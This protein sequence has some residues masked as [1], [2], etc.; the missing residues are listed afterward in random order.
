MVFVVPCFP[1]HLFASFKMAKALQAR[2]HHVTYL[3][4]APSESYVKNQGIPFVRIFKRLQEP[5]LDPIRMS[6]WKRYQIRK[7]IVRKVVET[8]D[9]FFEEEMP[10]IIRK[11]NPDLFVVD[12]G[13]P[14]MG[15][16]SYRFNIPTVLLSGWLPNTRDNNIPL[17]SSSIIPKKTWLSDLKSRWSWNIFLWRRSLQAKIG[18]KL[19]GIDLDFEEITR[20]FAVKAGYPLTRVDLDT[21]LPTPMLS[22]I[23][24]LVMCPE[25]F[26][27][28]RIPKAMIHYIEPAND[29]ERNFPKDVKIDWNQFDPHKPLLFVSFGN[30]SH[31]YPKSK[32]F[33]QK[34]I[35]VV[36]K[37]NEW[38][39]ILAVGEKYQVQEFQNQSSQ[40]L[41]VNCVSPFD[42]LPRA[43]LMVS[44]GGLNMIKEA[45]AHAVPMLLFPLSKHRDQFGNAA[46]VV[47]HQIGLRGNVDTITTRELQK[48]I[49]QVLYD[50]HIHQNI[51]VMKKVFW[52]KE[53]EERG[54]RFLETYMTVHK[55]REQE[56]G[57]AFDRS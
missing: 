45:I 38:Q 41:V 46:R 44:H 53:K 8:Y 33:F 15:L 31:L 13:W 26:D 55:R 10:E 12:H 7:E 1:G 4:E 14:F 18:V 42:V 50:R 36:A 54:V 37:N 27:F 29:F 56:K 24:M 23:P 57:L 49:Y 16:A 35:D 52:E 6:K 11:L 2:G 43:S 20:N 21:M 28:P 17:L 47:H 39:M 32:G 3:G 51:Q 34:I 9:R 19:L 40:I 5:I 25:E 22:N 30:H 48:M